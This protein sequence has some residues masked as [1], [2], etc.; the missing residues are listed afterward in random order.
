MTEAK[1]EPKSAAG[2]IDHVLRK[3]GLYSQAECADIPG[4]I[5]ADLIAALLSYAAETERVAGERQDCL[6]REIEA[7]RIDADNDAAHLRSAKDGS[8][9][10][11]ALF[12]K[13]ASINPRLDWQ[14]WFAAVEAYAIAA[15][16]RL[17]SRPATEGKR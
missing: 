1:S 17:S 3:H 4:T 10:V 6:A 14:E 15:E 5:G 9:Q 11:R 2:L 8:R 12:A 16:S 13:H 7:L